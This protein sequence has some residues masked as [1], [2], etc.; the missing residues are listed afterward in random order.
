V[1]T[2]ELLRRITADLRIL[3][4]KPVLRGLRISVESVLALLAARE[5]AE[6]VLAD[7]PELEAEDIRACVSY[8]HAVIAGESIEE[9]RVGPG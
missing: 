3:G 2:D 8:A 1:T 7:Y 6:T 4:G 9:V 5:S